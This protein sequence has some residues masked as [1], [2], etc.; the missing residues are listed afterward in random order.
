MVSVL[1]W[2]LSYIFCTR[3]WQS[4]VS[5]SRQGFDSV[6]CSLSEAVTLA[7]LH[8]NAATCLTTDISNFAVS[9][10]LEQFIE[11]QWQPIL[12]FSKTLSPGERNYSA[13][14]RALLDPYLTV[15]HFQFFVE[16]RVSP[17]NKD[18]SAFHF[19]AS[20]HY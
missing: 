12:F 15:R 11:G 13:F 17:I 9:T 18:P 19:C 2:Y 16:G 7:H 8:P 5:F 1:A 10:V 14:D 20:I 3:P 4:T 6:K